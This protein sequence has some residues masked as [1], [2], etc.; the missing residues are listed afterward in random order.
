MEGS[1]LLDEVKE[2]LMNDMWDLVERL[3][4]GKVVKCRTVLT[5]YG[6]DGELEKRKAQIVA[7]GFSQHHRIDF[8]DTFAIVAQLDSLRLLVTL[9]AQLEM[10][11]SQLNVTSA[12]LHGNMDV[13]MELPEI[14]DEMLTR[15][16]KDKSRRTVKNI[17][18]K[19]K[20]MLAD[21]R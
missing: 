15:I 10:S 18:G 1:H 21:L 16:L 11:I 9:S 14:L 5:K 8:Q 19:A 3:K 17:Q 7:R 2:L 13:Y 6:A 4:D 12:H 20:T